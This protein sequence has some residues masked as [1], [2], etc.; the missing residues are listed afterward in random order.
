MPNDRQERALNQFWNALIR[1]GESLDAALGDLDPEAAETVRRLRAMAQ[2]P[3]PA[4]A[5][6][7]AR[8]RLPGHIESTSGTEQVMFVTPALPH[9]SPNRSIAPDTTRGW[10]PSFPV[11]RERR[12]LAHAEFAT[13]LLLVLTLV[14]VW[15]AFHQQRDHRIA[16]PPG[17]STPPVSSPTDAPIFRGNAARTGEMP[18][19][20]PAEEPAERWHFTEPTVAQGSNYYYFSPVV[21]DGF[22]TLCI[23]GAVIAVDAE[24]GSERW[25]FATDSYADFWTPAVDGD[26]LYVGSGDGSLYAVDTTSGTERWHTNVGIMPP[27]SPVVVDGVLYFGAAA[28]ADGRA[29]VGDSMGGTLIALDAATGSERWRYKGADP[30]LYAV[31]A[32]SGTVRWHFSTE[33]RVMATPAVAD[34]V[35]YALDLG[36]RLH[37]VDAV[38]GTGRWST[39]VG[40]PESGP[41][42]QN[43]QSPAPAVM[44]DLVYAAAWDGTLVALDAASGTERWRTKIAYGAYSSP[45]VTADVVYIG[46]SDGTLSAFDAATGQLRWELGVDGPIGSSPVVTGGAVFVVRADRTLFRFDRL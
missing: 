20:G 5:R 22:V 17:T 15:F 44:G 38:R 31:D 11:S 28:V 12:R 25:R 30:G 19:P 27:S 3:P 13:A 9:V 23:P 26:T 7:R 6:E 46:G 29:Y 24:T 41:R 8:S 45:T 37:A 36:G 42:L 33:Q 14:A 32:V 43:F 35:V 1:P 10:L 4:S 18:G 2:T 40:E 16:A 34:G 39:Q 21:S